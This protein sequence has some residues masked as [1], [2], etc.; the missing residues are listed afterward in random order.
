MEA[1]G[2]TEEFV[3][4]GNATTGKDG[5]FKIGN[6]SPGRILVLAEKDGFALAESGEIFL[7]GGSDVKDV[8]IR[9]VMPAIVQGKVEDPDGKPVFGAEVSLSTAGLHGLR[10]TTTDDRGRF[11][12]DQ[13]IPGDFVLRAKFRGY[14]PDRKKDGVVSPG[15]VADVN[16]VLNPVKGIGG[17]VTTPAGVPVMRAFVFSDDVD[18]HLGMSDENGRFWLPG[19]FKSEEIRVWAEH[20]EWGPSSEEEFS[21]GAREVVLR[22][23]EPGSIVGQV[24][25]TVDGKPLGHYEVVANS[26]TDIEDTGGKTLGHK[27]TSVHDPEGRFELSSMPPGTYEVWIFAED[28]SLAQRRGLKVVTGKQTE[29]GIFYL[30]PG[31]TV[32]GRV[33]DDRTGLPLASARIRIDRSRFGLKQKSVH[34]DSEGKFRLTGIST[35]RVSIGVSHKGYWT[36]LISGI[37][38]PSKGELDLGIVRLEQMVEEHKYAFKYVGV[39]MGLGMWEGRPIVG[40]VFENSPAALAGLKEKTL[41]M[42]VN[43]IDTSELDLQRV[44]EL[45]RGKIGS[46]VTLDVLP[47][48]STQTKI[49]RIER[50]NIRTH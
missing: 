9:M 46:I 37:I 42:R 32:F 38:V 27:S 2:E 13:V 8:N 39:G 31:G 21:I 3:L 30:V 25:S 40:N 34:S 22:L 50:A 18:R 1:P 11:I 43:G 16:I 26:Y 23:T 4:E 36:E 29:A 10:R 15:K 47:P 20:S 35:E 45:I 49:V 6:L 5:V 48:G 7:D 17:E 14:A 28:Y 44:L 41:I 19:P 24:I 33:V 12:F